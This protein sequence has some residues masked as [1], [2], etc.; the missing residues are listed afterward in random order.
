M[1]GLAHPLSGNSMK[2]VAMKSGY[3]SKK[4]G[5]GAESS[6]EE[7]AEIILSAS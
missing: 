1:C 2:G 4:R 5:E 7:R 3:M 6:H